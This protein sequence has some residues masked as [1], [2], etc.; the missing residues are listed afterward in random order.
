MDEFWSTLSVI[1][2]VAVGLVALIAAVLVYRLV[3]KYRQVHRPGVPV[4]AKVAFW[5]PLVY[6]VFP[7]DALPDPIYLD[8][9]AVLIG[10]LVFVTA[11][12]RHRDDTKH[13][14]A[15]ERGRWPEPGAHS[16]QP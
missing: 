15:A 3:R 6:T 4:S 13:L 2:I 7:V 9:I 11:K 10:G 12:L 1:G 5:A 16:S 8:D 14:D